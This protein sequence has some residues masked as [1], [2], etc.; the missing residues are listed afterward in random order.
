MN[1][2][3]TGYDEEQYQKNLIAIRRKTFKKDL[4]WTALG[5]GSLFAASYWVS[6]GTSAEPYSDYVARIYGEHQACVNEIS[7]NGGSLDGVNCKMVNGR[8]VR[9]KQGE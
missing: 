2:N 4:L 9:S 1:P 3:W 5:L 7:R 8:Y 6:R